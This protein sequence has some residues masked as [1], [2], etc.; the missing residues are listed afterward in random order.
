MLARH[1]PCRQSPCENITQ[2]PSFILTHPTGEV[3]VYPH[4]TDEQT[5]VREVRASPRVPGCER[6][7]WELSRGAACPLH[8]PTVFSSDYRVC[9]RIYTPLRQCPFHGL[10][11]LCPSSF[12]LRE[13]LLPNLQNPAQLLPPSW[14]CFPY[15]SLPAEGIAPLLAVKLLLTS[16]SPPPPP[17]TPHSNRSQTAF[18]WLFCIPGERLVHCSCPT[19]EKGRNEELQDPHA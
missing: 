19:N 7:G 2:S 18:F 6:A 8:H 16:L 1:F 5:G 11:Y 12:F 17:Q 13:T 15:P 4:F 14:S 3:L 9:A 10:C